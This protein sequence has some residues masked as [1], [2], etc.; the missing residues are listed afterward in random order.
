MTFEGE[1]ACFV[2][3]MIIVA[4]KDNA[5]LEPGPG[6]ITGLWT[7]PAAH[8]ENDG[9]VLAWTDDDGEHRVAIVYS[10]EQALN[11][12]ESW[13]NWISP[14]DQISAL[15]E[16]ATWRFPPVSSKTAKLLT[17]EGVPAQLISLASYY[18]RYRDGLSKVSH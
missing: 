12:V 2:G 14:D 17:I 8:K 7:P 3:G 4:L 10:K 11:V 16:I 9:G 5:R 18:R 13:D 1:S 15:D 6:A